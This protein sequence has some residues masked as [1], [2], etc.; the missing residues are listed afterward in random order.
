MDR[1]VVLGMIGRY[2]HRFTTSEHAVLSEYKYSF[3]GTVCSHEHFIPLN[4]PLAPPP[5]SPSRIKKLGWYQ[6]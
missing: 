5:L 1:G 6:T 4:V 2:N 3:L